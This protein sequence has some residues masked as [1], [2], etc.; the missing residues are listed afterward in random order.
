MPANCHQHFWSNWMCLIHIVFRIQGERNNQQFCS[1]RYAASLLKTTKYCIVFE[2]RVREQNARSDCIQMN[3]A[4]C[5]YC[6]YYCWIQP[7]DVVLCRV[8]CHPQVSLSLRSLYNANTYCVQSIIVL[9]SKQFRWERRPKRKEKLNKIVEG[10]KIHNTGHVVHSHG[11]QGACIYG[12]QG[13]WSVGELPI[14]DD[15][16][17]MHV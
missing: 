8:A 10:W 1:W 13:H 7:G 6:Y 16:C 11:A 15:A 17:N 2:V 14:T 5:N 3:S 9:F 4:W 12:G